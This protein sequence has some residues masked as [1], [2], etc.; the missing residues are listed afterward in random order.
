MTKSKYLLGTLR[1]TPAAGIFAAQVNMP[2]AELVNLNQKI[3]KRRSIMT[4]QYEVPE[5]VEIGNASDL[6]LGT[7]KFLPLVPDS[8]GQPNR[9][10]S[11][12]DD[13]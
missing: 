6:I 7:D 4:N 8:P 10:D 1:P 12:S 2:I 13:E 5:V 3:S 9:T 11:M